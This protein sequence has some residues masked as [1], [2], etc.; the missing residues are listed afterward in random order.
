MQIVNTI[1]IERGNNLE[2]YKRS[3]AAAAT[4]DADADNN[5]YINDDNNNRP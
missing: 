5:D 3:A 2:F 4:A 1:C